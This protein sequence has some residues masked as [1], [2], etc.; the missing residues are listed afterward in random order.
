MTNEATCP[1]DTVLVI[2]TGVMGR[3]IAEVCSAA[4]L[5]VL[6]K[7]PQLAAAEKARA[8]IV[9]AFRK[10]AFKGRM[11][12]EAAASASERIGVDDGG[13]LPR[14]TLVVEAIY[15]DLS[16]KQ[17]LF[18]ELAQRA[19]KDTTL[20]SN[21]SSLSVTAIAASC[22]GPERVAGLHFFNPV[23]RMRLVEV[24]R[25]PRTPQSVVDDLVTLVRRLGMKPIVTIDAILKETAGF[26]AATVAALGQ[27]PER[28][29]DLMANIHAVTGDARYRPSLWLRR[30]VQLGLAL[31][32]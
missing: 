31:V 7:D 25:T 4:G 17:R 9:E 27:P 11:T 32:E 18:E 21:T 20:A 3:G 10:E 28:T 26:R 15:E 19:D 16:V 5:R 12:A 29:V 30:R 13:R 22:E 2:G 14:T 1:Y 23:P 6:L 24:V 8:T